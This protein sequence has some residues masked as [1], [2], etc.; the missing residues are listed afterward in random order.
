MA[1]PKTLL[2][3]QNHLELTDRSI[4][5]SECIQ[6]D[7]EQP[8]VKGF[9][10]TYKPEDPE[11]PKDEHADYHTKL[12]RDDRI[13]IR[14]LRNIAK[15]SYDD[16][17]HHTTYTHDQIHHALKGPLTPKKHKKHPIAIQGPLLERLKGFLFESRQHRKIPWCN[18]RFFV[19]GLQNFGDDAIN[20]AMKALGFNRKVRRRTLQFNARTRAKRIAFAQKWLQLKPNPED[21]LETSPSP[22]G[23]SDETWAHTCSNF[24]HWITIHDCE[25]EEEFE[26]LRIKGHGWMFWG[27]ICGKVKGPCFIWP[28]EFGGINAQKYIANIIPKVVRFRDDRFPNLIFQQDNGPSHRARITKQTFASHGIELMEWPPNS[29]DLNIIENVWA[30]MKHWLYNHY[31][32]ETLSLKELQEA[33]Y[34]AWEAVPASLLIN[35]ARSMPDRLRKVLENN[36]GHS[37]Y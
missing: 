20:S 8:V 2:Q 1:D 5:C 34:K 13:V 11:K 36:G 9:K 35:L 16:I 17:Y 31:D 29:P 19:P 26:L 30:W 18:L 22:V 33:I 15:F 10:P 3:N 32:T 12:T 21:W 7:A 37:G 14:T 6:R 4:V 24:T 23:F 27:M 28:K 25:S